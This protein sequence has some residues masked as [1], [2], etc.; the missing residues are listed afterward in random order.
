[1]V[2]MALQYGSSGGGDL[3]KW[4]RGKVER[5]NENSSLALEMAA[6][7]GEELV[8]YNIATRGTHEEPWDESWDTMAHATPGRYESAPGR[9]ASGTMIDAVGSWVSHG[10]DGKT[11]IGFGWTNPS[12]REA[13]F[14]AQEGGFYHNFTGKWIQGMYAIADAAD[15]VFGQ[16]RRDIKA[17]LKGA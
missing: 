7:R 16:L 5:I 12:K 10:V 15:E 2:K 13:Y 8:K 11:R 6:E 1:M 14:K 17:G 9:V 4:Y 3:V